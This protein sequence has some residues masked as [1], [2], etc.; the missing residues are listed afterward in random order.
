MELGHYDHE[1]RQFRAHFGEVHL[2]AELLPLV[3]GIFGLDNLPI[4]RSPPRRTTSQNSL[5]LQI[6]T[7]LYNFPTGLDGTGQTIGIIDLGGGFLTSDMDSFFGGLGLAGPKIV[8]FS[9]DGAVNNPGATQGEDMEVTVDIQVCGG[10]APGST[11]VVYIA[12]DSSQRSLIDAVNAA[13]TDTVNAPSVISIS[14]N[15]EESRFSLPNMTTLDTFFEAAGRQFITVLAASGDKGSSNGVAD[16]KAHVVFPASSPHVTA[17][18][19]TTLSGS[20]AGANSEVVWSDASGATGGGISDVFPLP[21]YQVGAGIPVS[22]NPAANSGRGVPDV[23]S[24][25]NGFNLVFQGAPFGFTGGTSEAAPL[26]A[27]LIALINQLRGA[28][29]FGVVP[30][31]FLNPI[32]YGALAPEGC[33]NDI[34]SGSNGAYTAGPGWDACTGWGSPIGSLLA[35]SLI[36]APSVISLSPDS[37]PHAGGTPVTIQGKRFTGAVSVRFGFF[38]AA[39]VVDNDTQISAVSP[40]IPSNAAAEPS[41]VVVRTLRGSSAVSGPSVFIYIDP[42]PLVVRVE[43]ASGPA[44]TTVTVTGKGF[45]G[46]T[47]VRFGAIDSVNVVPD[48][49]NPDTQLT[50][51][52]PPAN[53]TVHVIVVTQGGPSAPTSADQFTNE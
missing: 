8:P 48:P 3:H 11:I 38:E 25:A 1:G 47:A 29:G 26:W 12:P 18:G 16:G 14:N 37:G 20:S 22:A 17:C 53:G 32:L 13:M 27:G 5:D 35:N 41:F 24:T 39:F 42:I 33:L 2:D 40:G 45:T 21:S 43:P 9:V 19:G 49:N 51:D 7:S 46:V 10:I 31:G 30:V 50:A 52:S 15:G 36:G 34:T 6:V 4:F 23:A 28:T 44:G